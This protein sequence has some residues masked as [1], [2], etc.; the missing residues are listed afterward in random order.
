M[1]LGRPTQNKL[2]KLRPRHKRPPLTRSQVMARIRSKDTTPEVRVRSAVHAL[3]LRFRKHVADLPGKPD[4]ANQRGK[5]AIFIH[6]CFWHSHEGCR[7]AS[8]P[9]SNS[10]YWVPKLQRNVERDRDKFRELQV[11]GYRVLVVWECET[12]D[13]LVLQSKLV[14]F[15]EAMVPFRRA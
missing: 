7:L 5:W 6:G 14:T 12:R 11:L 2:H 15:V 9:K 3:G 10:S 4:L 1:G 8:R 13:P